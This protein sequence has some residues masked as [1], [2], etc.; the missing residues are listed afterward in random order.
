VVSEVISF[1]ASVGVVSPG[2][3]T[4]S[5]TITFLDGSTTLASLPLTEGRATFT[6]ASL[7][8]GNHVISAHYSGDGNFTASATPG[9]G[10]AVKMDATATSIS[11]SAN[12]ATA[13]HAVTFTATVRASA[14]GSGTPT[15]TVTF[16]DITTVLGT[17]TLNSAGQAT[18]STSAL[19]VGTH[20]ITASYAGD[21]NFTGSFSPNIAEV[22]KA[23]GGSTAMSPPPATGGSRSAVLSGSVPS[24]IHGLS[25]QSLD[26][27]FSSSGEKHRLY[28]SVLPR[29]HPRVVTEDPLDWPS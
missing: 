18:F 5:G 11:S 9:Y 22:V 19:A 15:G 8:R 1:I 2:R 29:L 20:A 7:S 17:G 4:P 26:S 16:K 25:P 28:P 13:G 14:P 10:E 3:G 21:T 27:F 12:P 6:T 24:P 23:S